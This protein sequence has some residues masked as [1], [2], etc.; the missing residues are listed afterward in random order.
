MKRLIISIDENKCTGCGLCVP[1]C[2]ESALQIVD[3]KAR[4]V[5]EALCDGMG[6]CIEQCPYGALTVEERE[7]EEFDPEAVEAFRRAQ[8]EQAGKTPVAGNISTGAGGHVHHISPEPDGAAGEA[9][10]AGAAGSG[11]LA[12]SG[13]HPEA[14]VEGAEDE[15]LACGCPA[16]S[17][18]VIERNPLPTTQE[19]NSGHRPVVSQ[20]A[21]WPVQ[22]ALVSPKAPFFREA[23]L[24]VSADCVPFAYAGFH[25]DLLRGRALVV[26]CPKLDDARAYVEKLAAIIAMNNLQGITVAHM[27]VGCCYGLE[28]IVRE[29]VARAGAKVPVKSLVV[30]VDGEVE[31]E[32]IAG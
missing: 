24:L 29:A 15:P 18:R 4:L 25:Q 3:G 22:L 11:A 1:G 12:T 2:A 13:A 17:T 32:E 6:A 27:E 26:G 14:G 21:Q 8:Q 7:A 23:D 20:L 10:M 28:R 19:L 30:T 9:S 5:S 16:S 31:I